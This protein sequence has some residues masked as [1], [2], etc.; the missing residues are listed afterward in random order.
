MQQVF[1]DSIVSAVSNRP[2]SAQDRK[3]A[4]QKRA[5]ETQEQLLSAASE[6]FSTLGYDGVSVRL[7]ETKAGVQ[8]G[9]VAYHFGTK[10]ALWK[11]VVDAV[12]AR[13]DDRMG[14]SVET[15]RDLPQDQKLRAFVSTFVRF[16][17][18]VPE[19]NRLMV[20]EGKTNSW[21]MDYIVDEHVAPL[22]ERLNETLGV[23]IDP[24]SYYVMVGSGSF[25]FS[26]SD[27]CRRLFKVDPLTDEFITAH[28]Q[29][30]ANMIGSL[31][32]TE[33]EPS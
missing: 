17:A 11:Q 32:Q 8:R 33:P 21:R 14:R 28:A 5:E 13:M 18:E 6:L 1:K 12:F 15:I 9:L 30:V 4:P 7:V 29:L 16:S 25:V 3:R 31:G 24:H 27:E 2:P 10:E 19:L 20:Q 22:L 26:V 23:K